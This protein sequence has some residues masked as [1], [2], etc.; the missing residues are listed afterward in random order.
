MP[1]KLMSVLLSIIMVLVFSSPAVKAESSTVP[2]LKDGISCLDALNVMVGIASFVDEPIIEGTFVESDNSCSVDVDH[3]R[4]IAHAGNNNLTDSVTVT[5]KNL[6]DLPGFA[7]T[8]VTIYGLTCAYLGHIDQQTQMSILDYSIFEKGRAGKW[9][10]VFKDYEFTFIYA[11]EDEYCYSLTLSLKASDENDETSDNQGEE[12]YKTDEALTLLQKMNADTSAVF[13]L[14]K[15]S[16]PGKA[17]GEEFQYYSKVN[18]ALTSIAPDAVS[19]VNLSYQDGGCIELYR[20]KDDAVH[21]GIILLGLHD[22]YPEISTCMLVYQNAI[23]WLSAD[24]SPEE[25]GDLISA[26]M[27]AVGDI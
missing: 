4:L 16:D 13:L 8:L 6:I 14:D 24:I 17:L 27:T 15:E 19:D 23:L 18:F 1:K 2:T 10:R 7:A 20:T 3:F 26:F 22:T 5:A 12:Q 25:M 9:A 11:P 21:R